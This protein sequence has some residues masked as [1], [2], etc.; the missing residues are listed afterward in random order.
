M[1]RATN[2]K[3]KYNC[4]LLYERT[5]GTPFY[6][7][8][9][10]TTGVKENDRIVELAIL[11]CRIKNGK[12]IIDE[13]HDIYIRPPFD[14][15]QKVIDIHGITNEFLADKPTEEELFPVIKE[16]F[17]E[18]PILIGHNVEFDIGMVSRMYER[19]GAKFTYQIGL[20]TLDMARDVLFGEDVPDYKLGS[21]LNITGL[22]FGL[23]FHN[24]LDDIRGTLRLLD[25]CYAEYKELPEDEENKDL[26]YVNYMYFWKGYNKKQSGMYVDTN[27]GKIYYS[28]FY[29][30]WF[31]SKVDLSKC[32][33]R[34]LETDI[35]LKTGL[36][37]MREY[38]RMT[39]NKF[40]AL[41]AERR[42][43]NIYL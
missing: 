12:A 11:K 15:D 4:K 3:Y 14:M 33:I 26:L 23:T 41:K 10:E 25:Y 22:D 43:L 37:S 32:N 36:P 27:L 42:K 2:E 24:A 19:H 20:D 38:G 30:C 34:A 39:E 5:N 13:E 31:S 1:Y 17:G 9:T 35:L 6:V 29:K 40:K 21:L 18:R 7:F 28:T 8:D 16:I